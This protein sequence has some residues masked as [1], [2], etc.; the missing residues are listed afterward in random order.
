MVFNRG[1]VLSGF[2]PKSYGFNMWNNEY[3]HDCLVWCGLTSLWNGFAMDGDFIFFIYFIFNFSI[4]SLAFPQC[5]VLSQDPQEKNCRTSGRSSDI[6]MVTLL[7]Q[8]LWSYSVNLH[9]FPD[10]IILVVYCTK[11]II[12]QSSFLSL[13]I[14]HWLWQEQWESNLSVAQSELPFSFS[15]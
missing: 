5:L 2:W 4:Y 3:L 11:I 13:S 1:T 6:K 10:M 9:P 15:C 14:L 7:H 8:G 12:L